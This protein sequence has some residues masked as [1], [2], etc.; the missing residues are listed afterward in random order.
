MRRAF[1]VVGRVVRAAADY[2]AAARATTL[3][4][5]RVKKLSRRPK[6]RL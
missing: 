5:T 1:E 4:R 6:C 3:A 2:L